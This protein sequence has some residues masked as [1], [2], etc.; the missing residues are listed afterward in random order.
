MVV[1]SRCAG[2]RPKMS[3]ERARFAFLGQSAAGRRSRHENTASFNFAAHIE[4]VASLGTLFITLAVSSRKR[5]V[6]VWRP[7]VRLSVCPVRAYST[8][9]T[10]GSTR[11]GQHTFPSDYYEDSYTY[12]KHYR[13]IIVVVT[14]YHIPNFFLQ[15]MLVGLSW[16]TTL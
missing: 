12:Y 16:V 14:F 5:N 4:S 11:R 13:L 10:K 7:S 2:P 3:G 6:T 1:S 9:L 15:M 8:W